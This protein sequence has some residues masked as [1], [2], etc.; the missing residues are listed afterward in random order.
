MYPTSAYIQFFHYLTWT[1]NVLNESWVEKFLYMTILINLIFQQSIAQIETTLQYVVYLK[2]EL[3]IQL[4][5][6]GKK[7]TKQ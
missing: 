7:K 1:L 2:L 6:T 4:L 3:V 5:F